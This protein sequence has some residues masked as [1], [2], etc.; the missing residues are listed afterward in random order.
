MSQKI[1]K[2]SKKYIVSKHFEIYGGFGWTLLATNPGCYY[3]GRERERKR[4]R[5][6]TER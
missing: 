5:V 2:L 3:M 1:C 4:E 6:S